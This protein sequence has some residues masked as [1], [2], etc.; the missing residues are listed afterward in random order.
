VTSLASILVFFEKSMDVCIVCRLSN[1]K[2][3]MLFS[4]ELISEYQEYMLR[5]HGVEVSDSQAQID[6]SNLSGLYLAFTKPDSES[7][8]R[9]SFE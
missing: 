9:Q 6:L 1:N 2:D 3:L 7:V 4:A 5:V 8:Q